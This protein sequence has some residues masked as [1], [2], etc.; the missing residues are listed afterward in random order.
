MK[1]YVYE[2]VCHDHKG[3]GDSDSLW[4][5]DYAYREDRLFATAAEAR[6][7]CHDCI[8]AGCWYTE[9]EETGE[10]IT[11]IPDFSVEKIS[12]YEACWLDP[13]EDEDVID[14][15]VGLHGGP[16]R[17]SSMP[18]RVAEFLLAKYGDATNTWRRAS[19]ALVGASSA[20]HTAAFIGSRFS[21]RATQIRKM[22]AGRELLADMQAGAAEQGED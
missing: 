6:A 4:S 9:D 1:N 11:D 8:H 22:L 2:L 15:M 18:R 7:V 20:T 17:F 5:P 12:V 16:I 21:P 14:R 3:W 19:A 10:R 13:D